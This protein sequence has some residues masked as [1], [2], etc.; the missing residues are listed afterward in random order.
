MKEI[1][2]LILVLV[3]LF[4][5]SKSDVVQVSGRIENGD[6]IVSILVDDS[7]YTLSLDQQ[8]F[9]SGKIDM[10]KGGY[11]TMLHNALNLYLSPGEDLEIYVN[12]KNFSGSLYFRGSLGGIN[13]Y[14]KEQEIAVFFDKDYYALNEEEF[15]Q[16]MR[17]LIDEKV[18]L[19]E[20]KNFDDSFTELEKPTNR[21]FHC[22]KS[23]VVSLFPEEYVSGRRLSSGE[24][25]FPI[26][27]PLSR[28]IMKG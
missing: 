6:S 21:I 8:G 17:A 18:K 4:S 14:L 26:S 5:C 16:K 22:C 1:I 13:S 20:A 3:S 10:V 19:L 7:I 2:V 23:V 9:F 28:L 12:A 15:V 25:F 27:Y 11:A 24:C